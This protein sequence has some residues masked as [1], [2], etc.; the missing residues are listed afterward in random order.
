MLYIL[1][2]QTKEQHRYEF[3]KMQ[4]D[5]RKGTF[6]LLGEGRGWW[7]LSAMATELGDEQEVIEET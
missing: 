3:S 6:I 4:W 5:P 7:T 1:S 2:Q